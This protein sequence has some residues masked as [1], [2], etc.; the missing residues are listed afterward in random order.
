MA[1]T[2]EWMVRRYNAKLSNKYGS[3]QM[4]TIAKSKPLSEVLKMAMQVTSLPPSTLPVLPFMRAML[5]ILLAV[6]TFVL[7]R[8]THGCATG[9]IAPAAPCR[10][11][12]PRVAHG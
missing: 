6:P 3:P 7:A 10:S 2:P 1:L 4:E 8:L 12:R 9:P 11:G 5:L